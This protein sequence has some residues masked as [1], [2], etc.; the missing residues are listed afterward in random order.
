MRCQFC[1]NFEAFIYCFALMISCC[2]CVENSQC[3]VAHNGRGGPGRGRPQGEGVALPHRP[4]PAQWR[5]QSLEQEAAA[6]ELWGR[7]I[8]HIIHEGQFSQ[9]PPELA[10][11]SHLTEVKTE[12]RRGYKTCHLTWQEQAGI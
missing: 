12:P 6:V 2:S 9:R 10:L 1:N 7:C 8:I 4:C 11:L 3:L 5:G